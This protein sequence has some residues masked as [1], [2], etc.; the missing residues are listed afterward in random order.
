MLTWHV[1][2]ASSEVIEVD[3][4]QS[5]IDGF[6]GALQQLAACRDTSD[7]EAW[8]YWQQEAT[9]GLAAAQDLVGGR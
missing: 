2:H 5:A 7:P 8:A 4:V 6:R 1:C 9:R 3:L